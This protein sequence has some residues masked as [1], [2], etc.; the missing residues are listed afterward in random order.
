MQNLLAGKTAIITG[1]SS[2]IGR[3]IAELFA[4]EGASLVVNARRAGPLEELAAQIGAGGD[5]VAAVAGD[6]ADPELCE[7]L[8]A[9]AET[10]FGGLDIAVNNAGITGEMGP[11]PGMSLENWDAVISVNLTAAF[12]AARNQIPAM[13]RRGGGSLIFVSSFVGHTSGFPGMSAYA[14][15]KAGV[16]GLARNLAAEHG[17]DGVRVNAL[18]PGGTDTPMNAARQ[19]GAGPEVADFINSLH[20][21][22]RIARPDEIARAA[23]FLASD[24][25]SF[26]TGSALMAD[27]AVS[28]NKT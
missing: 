21:L 16:I 28:V 23:V 26:V 10:R 15:A 4:A 3:A 22:K 7:R 1:A 13:L 12:L 5:A 6:A 19:P 11:V 25:S 9:T 24:L 14:A 2:G 17:P 8:V 20:A 18:L 27:G